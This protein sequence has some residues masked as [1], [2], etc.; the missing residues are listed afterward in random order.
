MRVMQRTRGVT[1]VCVRHDD[2]A[3]SPGAIGSFDDPRSFCFSFW[4]VQLR[5]AAAVVADQ[6]GDVTLSWS[7]WQV[8]TSLPV[9]ALAF[10][11]IVFVAMLLW[12]MVSGR[13]SARPNESAG[14]DVID[15]TPVDAMPSPK[16]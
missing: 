9:L 12:S 15:V 2:S 1:A 8:Q 5:S 4:S 3:F 11:I 6:T 16:A 13:V 14:C 7:A 10:V